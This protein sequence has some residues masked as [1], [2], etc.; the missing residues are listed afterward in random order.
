MW[1]GHLAVAIG[2][3][4]LLDATLDQA[5]KPEWGSVRAGPIAVELGTDFWAGEC[6]FLDDFPDVSVRY[7]LFPRQN[8]FARARDARRSH[9]LPLADAIWRCTETKKPLCRSRFF[10]VSEVSRTIRLTRERLGH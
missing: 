4:W 6:I 1:H 7:K 8:G 10:R 5:N 2:Q 3:E 9:W